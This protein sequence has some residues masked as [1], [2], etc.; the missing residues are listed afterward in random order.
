MI[1]FNL[2]KLE[3]L[4]MDVD[5]ARHN[6]IEQQI[7]SWEVLDP[8]ILELLP[9]VPREE[10]VPKDFKNLAFADTNIDLGHGQVMMTPKTEARILQSLQIKSSDI[11]LEIGTGSGYLTA[12]LAKLG[13]NITSYEYF[14][15][16]SSQAKT[17]L[18]LQSI[19]NVNLINKDIF[20]DMPTESSFDVIVITGS[21]C[22]ENVIFNNA[23]KIGGR[24]LQIIGQPPVKEAILLTRNG[25]ES[26]RTESIFEMDIA[27]LIGAEEKP[28]F[29]F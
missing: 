23:L 17:N 3:K 20:Q 11:V 29:Q 19:N 15:D 26:W 10:F 1:A 5:I 28:S 8:A 9:E 13:Q 16:I 22:Q 6:M 24:L 14:A 18:E 12:L 21:M 7:R 25:E 2:T 27:P 4:L